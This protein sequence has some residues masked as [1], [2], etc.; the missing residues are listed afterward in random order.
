FPRQCA[1]NADFTV[2]PLP[3]PRATLRDEGLSDSFIGYM[4]NWKGFVAD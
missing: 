4:G 2:R 3:V 1:D